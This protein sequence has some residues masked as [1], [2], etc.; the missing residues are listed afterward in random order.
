MYM[1]V[2]ISAMQALKDSFTR[3]IECQK[4]LRRLHAY[5]YATRK[6][7]SADSERSSV[8]N[9]SLSSSSAKIEMENAACV[10]KN[11][12][13]INKRTDVGLRFCIQE[14]HLGYL[15]SGICFQF[16]IFL[17]TLAT[18][19]NLAFSVLVL[20]YA[21]VWLSTAYA[22][23]MGSKCCVILGVQLLFLNMNV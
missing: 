17:T 23:S 5:K 21:F 15:M 14:F 9:R 18:L 20:F 4:W 22:Q 2:C 3:F 8:A 10:E 1:C 13:K 12:K 7:N 19:T 16:C 11:I 6:E